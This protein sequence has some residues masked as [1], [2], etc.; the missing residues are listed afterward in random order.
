MFCRAILRYLL[1]VLAIVAG[2]AAGR[3]RAAAELASIEATFFVAPD[4]NDAWSGKL[5]APNAERTDGPFATLEKGA[6]ALRAIDRKGW[7]TPLL[8]LVR[9]GKYFLDNSNT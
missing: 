5:A 9:G 2:L 8:V 3:A 4:G 1:V 6:D 7:T